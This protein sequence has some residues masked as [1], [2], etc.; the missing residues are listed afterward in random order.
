M[1]TF[2]YAII[3]ELGIHARPAGM[4]SDLWYHGGCIHAAPGCLGVPACQGI[5]AP[6]PGFLSF[7]NLGTVQNLFMI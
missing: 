1:I 6:M 5:Y 2:K 7:F 3:D 4:R